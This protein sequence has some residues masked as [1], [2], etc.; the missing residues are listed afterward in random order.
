MSGPDF[1]LCWFVLEQKKNT[2]TVLR[3]LPVKLYFMCRWLV[4]YLASSTFNSVICVGRNVPFESLETS[5]CMGSSLEL[6]G[7][8][9]PKHHLAL[10]ELVIEPTQFK[11]AFCSWVHP[12]NLWRDDSSSWAPSGSSGSWSLRGAGVCSWQA[13]PLPWCQILPGAHSLFREMLP[14]RTQPRIDKL[15][16]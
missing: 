2:L 12:V 16:K 9:E 11:M 14:C 6:T 10:G 13:S 1:V 7:W 3:L 15:R 5:S 4:T 8:R